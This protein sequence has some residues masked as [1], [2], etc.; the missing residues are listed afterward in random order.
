V[1][2]PLP[3]WAWQFEPGHLPELPAMAAPSPLTTEWAFGSATGRGVRVAVIDSGI[4]GSHPLVGP[5]QGGVVLEADGPDGVRVLEG[6]HDD[7]FGHGTACAGIIRSL[8]PECELYSV[9]VLGNRLTGRGSVF[10][11]G[12]RWAIEQGM[13]VVNISMSTRRAELFSRFHRLADQAYFA[14]TVLV[15]AVNNVPAPSYPSEFASVVSV[16]CA[17]GE[18]PFAL[19]YNPRPPV[20][21]GAPGTDVDIAWLG[22]RTVRASGNS[23]A[24]PRVA[25]M[26]ALLKERH[27]QLTPFEIK[28]ALRA[29]AGNTAVSR[30]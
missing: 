8:A 10:A 29:V 12:V 23:F 26:V 15:C 7:L 6:P 20:E 9:R 25:G 17:P 1:T 28:T 11:A 4:D 16:A 22:G 5:V 13:D 18:G 21:F 19:S 27:P 2:S 3:A 14:G 30:A 24:A